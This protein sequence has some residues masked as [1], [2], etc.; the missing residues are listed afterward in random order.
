MDISY[1]EG[2]LTWMVMACPRPFWCAPRLEP[3]DRPSIRRRAPIHRQGGDMSTKNSRQRIESMRK[4]TPWFDATVHSPTRAGWY[5]CQE[6]KARHY[7]KDGLWYRNRRSID[8]WSMTISKMHW[9]GLISESLES[10][11]SRFDPSVPRSVEEL[12]WEN[13]APVGMEF[14][15]PDFGKLIRKSLKDLK[16]GKLKPSPSL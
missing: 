16:K 7:Y 14:G 5:D 1:A 3:K 4:L 15:S 8:R 11:L 13:T 2:Q 9:R 10:L 6:C 12:A